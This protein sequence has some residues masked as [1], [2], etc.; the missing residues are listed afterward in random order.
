MTDDQ[1]STEEPTSAEYEVGYGKPPQ[2]TRFQ[3]GRSG[4]SRGRPKE[5]KNLR[6]DLQE[7][8][9]EKILV[10]EGEQ[11]RRVSKQRAVVKMLVTR[12]L[13][14]DAR[15]ATLLMSMMMRLTDTGEGAPEIEEPLHDDEMEIF[16]DYESACGETLRPRHRADAKTR[17]RRPHERSKP[18][19]P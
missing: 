6:T 10:R 13:K 14:G 16:R 2:H 5:T 8:L 3:P 19:S 9:S 12:T 17:P 7:E 11:S 18:G 15:A 1:D 4:N